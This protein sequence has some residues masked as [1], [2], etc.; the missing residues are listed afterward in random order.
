MYRLNVFPNVQA[1]YNLQ[2]SLVGCF[3]ADQSTRN[4][5]Q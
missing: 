3:S 1:Q 4:A 2:F 5:K